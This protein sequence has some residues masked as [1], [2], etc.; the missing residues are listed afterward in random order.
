MSVQ[1]TEAPARRPL[2][3]QGIVDAALAYIDQHGIAALSMHK[4]GAVLGVKAMS[5]YNHVAG[6]DDVLDGVVELLWC[7]A[8]AAAPPGPDW[9]ASYRGF[10]HALRDVIY[11]HPQAGQLMTTRQ[12][13]P[14]PALRL[15]RAHIGAATDAG[16][17]PQRA[18][19]LLRTITAYALGHALAYLNW[20]PCTPGTGSDVTTLLAPDVPDA[21]ADVAAV[22]CGQADPAAEFD[23]GLNLMLRAAHGSS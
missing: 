12:K 18:Y 20:A 1:A 10:G 23:L 2:T 16:L 13:I 19:P 21:L 9:P 14:T 5:L 6:K 7:E 22:F 15:V 11:R 3:R 17:A 4:L 8:E